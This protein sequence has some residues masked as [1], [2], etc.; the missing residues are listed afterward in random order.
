MWCFSRWY[1]DNAAVENGP[2]PECV[3][4][5]VT[6]ST[7]ICSLTLLYKCFLS[8]TISVK[9]FPCTCV[10]GSA[11]LRVSSDDCTLSQ[12]GNWNSRHL[13]SGPQRH[14]GPD[15]NDCQRLQGSATGHRVCQLD[16]EATG[17]ESQNQQSKEKKLC[18]P[19]WDIKYAEFLPLFVFFVAPILAD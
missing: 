14:F 15:R 2:N 16:F 10:W 5:V 8:D 1:N 13:S 11:G 18:V 6:V 4:G 9:A 17:P 12:H 19:Y 7:F 3:L